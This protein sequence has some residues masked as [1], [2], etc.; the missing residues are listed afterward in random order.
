[1]WTIKLSN[2]IQVMIWI[3]PLMGLVIGNFSGLLGLGG[4]WL[5]TPALNI[6]GFPATTSVGTSL[7]QMVGTSSVASFKHWRLG[8]LNWRLTGILIFPMLGGVLIGREIMVHLEG[9]G[10]S[11][12]VLRLMHLSVAA[13]MAISLNKNLIRSKNKVVAKKGFPVFGPTLTL[14]GVKKPI[15]IYAPILISLLSGVLSA[16]MG[17]GGSLVT[18]PALVSLLEIPFAMAVG[19]N[20]VCVVFSALVGSIG[21]GMND[22]VNFS[23]AG[24]ILSGSLI[25]SY[26]GASLMPYCR[27]SHIKLIFGL[28]LLVTATSIGFKQL[29][30]DVLSQRSIFIGAGILWLSLLAPAI[31]KRMNPN[32]GHANSN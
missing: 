21:Y 17:I 3:F 2:G 6:L 14:S 25:G 4:G 18:I 11:D 7:A 5:L 8:N 19:S 15:P 28:L 9:L 12:T 23:A 10:H 26:M 31:K 13:F 1:M 24:L 16:L 30:W 32:N 27:E 22:M 20:L 29:G